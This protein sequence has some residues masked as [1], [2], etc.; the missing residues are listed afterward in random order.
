MNTPFQLHPRLAQDCIPLGRF[1]LCLLLLMNDSRYP[2]CILVPRRPGI[3]EIHQ[4]DE[5]DQMHLQRESCEL[6]RRL[7][8][9]F[10][11]DKMNIATLGNVVPQLHI[12]HIV[13]YR[14]DPAWPHPVWGRL[15]PLPYETM[16]LAEVKQRL[17]PLLAEN[18]DF[19]AAN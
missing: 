17:L 2:W 4:L 9:C 7:A 6:A 11:A 15:P 18:E 16:A 10:A 19:A 1:R 12:H 14:H 13:R 5:G 3:S 8:Q